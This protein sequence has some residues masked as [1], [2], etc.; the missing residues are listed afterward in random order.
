MLLAMLAAPALEPHLARPLSSRRA[1]LRMSSSPEAGSFEL[2]LFSPARLSLFLRVQPRADGL[3]DVARLSQAV[4]LGDRLQLARIPN[5]PSQAAG[6]VRP[7]RKTDPI[8]QHV[9]FSATPVG[10]PGLPTDET[11]SVVRALALYRTRLAQRDGGSLAVPRFRAHLAKTLPIDAG[12]GGAASNAAAA[13]VGANELCGGRASA[14]ELREW[15]I[16]GLGGLG[17]DVASLLLPGGLGLVTG[18]S[19]FLRG[20]A[21]APVPAPLA[22]PAAGS[23]LVV[24]PEVTLSTP[25]LFRD[26]AAARQAGLAARL[27]AG[28]PGAADAQGV[29]GAAAPN[30]AAPEGAA[31]EALLRALQ[32]GA[33]GD[34]G[35]GGGKQRLPAAGALYVNDL[36]AAALRSC[37]E[38]A[39]VATRLR[40]DEGFDVVS[41]S[42]AGPAL[43]ALGRPARGEEDEA[44]AARVAAEC[45]AATGVRVRAWTARFVEGP[46]VVRDG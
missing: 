25:A 1:R 3:H 23:L 4:D 30:A 46:R 14:E 26:L 18:R 31:P 39:A 33:G 12:L 15:A 21:V 27:A 29:P 17:T 10:L 35:A 36:H 42:G 16:D 28:P 2:E 11:N 24:A 45:E 34:N 41:L 32:A 19:V 37:P 9:E 5:S 40:E 8:K 22:Q 7:S 6:V 43:F 13:L 20:D 38:V 44:F